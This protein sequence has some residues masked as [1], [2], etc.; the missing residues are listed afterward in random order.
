MVTPVGHMSELADT[1]ELTP[2]SFEARA[3]GGE[4]VCVL[5]SARWCAAGELLSRHLRATDQLECPVVVVDV[6]EYPHLADR[7]RVQSL[8]AVVMLIGTEKGRLRGAFGLPQVRALMA[9]HRPADTV[10]VDP[11]TPPRKRVR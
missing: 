2:N 9:R 6:D 4:Q 10:D 1:G 11:D 8:P 7:Y 5:F 3:A